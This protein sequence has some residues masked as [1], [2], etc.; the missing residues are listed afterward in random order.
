MRKL[1][2]LRDPETGAAA[3]GSESTRLTKHRHF[4]ECIACLEKTK[5][6]PLERMRQFEVKLKGQ[7]GSRVMPI[8][9]TAI[10]AMWRQLAREGKL[11]TEEVEGALAELRRDAV[12]A[13]SKCPDCGALLTDPICI[14]DPKSNAMAF[15]CPGCS[16]EG[17]RQRW[18]AEG[19]S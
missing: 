14:L 1:F 2:H 11:G 13:A 19:P 3:C 6:H 10:E 4:A 16:S 9:L 5:A 12:I 17:L 18:E 8:R 15:G 7:D